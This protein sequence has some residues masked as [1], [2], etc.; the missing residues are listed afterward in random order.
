MHTPALKGIRMPLY[1]P[2]APAVPTIEGRFPNGYGAAVDS[3]VKMAHWLEYFEDRGGKVVIHGVTVTDLNYFSRMYD[4]VV[5]AVGGGELG[6]LFTP[7]SSRFSGAHPRVATQVFVEGFEPNRDEGLFDVISAPQGRIC[8]MPILTATGPA[9]SVLVLD[10]PG[11]P[12]DGSHLKDNA[13]HANINAH[14][15]AAWVKDSVSRLF[16]DF[17]PRLAHITAVDSL[18]AVVE[19]ITPQVRHPVEVLDTGGAVLGSADVVV[20]SDPIAGQGWN[21]S[22]MC[23]QTYLKRILDHG[24]RPFDAEWM[25]QTFEEFY[26]GEG[27]HS[28]ALSHM[29]HTLWDSDL[30]DFFGEI[31]GGA[32]SIPEVADRYVH[33]VDEPADYAEWF[34]DPARARAYLA[35]AA[36]R[37]QR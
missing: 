31:V 1:V 35:E 6:A 13:S 32:L 7:D 21:L 28:A 33:G 14:D 11:G 36:E 16:P 26:A 24:E 15:V 34:M 5:V 10:S 30:P 9:H 27:V 8:C 12:L 25:R 20:T 4:L 23:A 19:R 18:A 17:A 37:H 2:G 22:T 29:M 3:R